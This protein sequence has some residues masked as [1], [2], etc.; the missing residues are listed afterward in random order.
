MR[1]ETI[2]LQLLFNTIRIETHFPDG[3]HG[4]GTGFLLDHR[5]HKGEAPF[6]VTC[7]HLVE[8]SSKG[9]LTMIRGS[10]GEPLLGKAFVSEVDHFE[11]VWHF[12]SDKEI[13]VAVT[14]VL[15]VLRQAEESKEELFYRAIQS[16][17]VLDEK[18]ITDLDALEELAFIG[19]PTGH[20]DRRNL[21]PI[22][23]RG[24]TATPASVDYNGRPEFLID[25][26]VFPGSSGSPVFLYNP[27]AY[28]TSQG[29]VVIGQRLGLL[30][31]LC[32]AGVMGSS[33]G[34]SSVVRTAGQE[35]L[36]SAQM[37]D[38]GVVVKSKAIL[39]T[40]DGFLRRVDSG[41][42]WTGIGFPHQL[43]S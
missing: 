19:Y 22:I 27:V 16:E 2:A 26:S 39:E 11:N 41:N 5:N 8:G 31:I 7:R 34:P 37:V 20:W 21:L 18:T 38:L 12:H 4:V 33:T 15:P 17:L 3:S 43:Q 1:V 30:G 28:S 24:T 40:I 14:P 25:A 42:P 35:G 13:D 29:A 23:R 36:T 6:I 10:N 32:R 9:Q